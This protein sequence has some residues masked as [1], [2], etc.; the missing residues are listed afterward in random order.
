[1]FVFTHYFQQSDPYFPAGTLVLL[2]YLPLLL[3]KMMLCVFL[4]QAVFVVVV[5]PVIFRQLFINYRER[6]CN[7]DRISREDI[8][9]WVKYHCTGV[10]LHVEEYLAA[11]LYH[12]GSFSS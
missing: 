3:R 10:L 9:S 5:T 11:G 7:R 8:V 4:L 12:W 6:C 2:H 1:M